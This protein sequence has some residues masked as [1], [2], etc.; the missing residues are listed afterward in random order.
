MSAPAHG[1]SLRNLLVTE[2]RAEALR[3]QAFDLPSVT[4]SRRQLCDLE[5]LLNGAFSPLEG[6][7]CRADYEQVLATGRLADGTLWP[8]PVTLA[9]AQ[10]NAEG[11]EQGKPLV[12]RDEEG[13]MLAVVKAAELWQPDQALEAEAVYGTAS[14]EHP[15]V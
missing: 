15:G 3:S 14:T 9:L 12:L 2:A 5:L 7:L 8:I 10:A 11:I 4:L 13:F 6:F 1:G